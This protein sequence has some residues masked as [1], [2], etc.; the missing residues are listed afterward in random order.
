MFKLEKLQSLF[1]AEALGRYG[2]NADK[3]KAL[4][5]PR[6]KNFCANANKNLPKAE[7]IQCVAEHGC[8]IDDTCSQDEVCR[9]KEGGGF[10][11]GELH[12]RRR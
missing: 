8:G 3:V 10:Y 2:I 12:I 7:Q 9:T 4:Y 6:M 11:C 5:D 1:T